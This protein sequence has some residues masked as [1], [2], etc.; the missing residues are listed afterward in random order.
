M[1]VAK[2]DSATGRFTTGYTAKIIKSAEINMDTLKAIAVVPNSDYIK[3]MAQNIGYFDTVI[4]IE[5]LEKQIISANLTNE[6]QSVNSLIGMN[7]AARKYKPFVYLTFSKEV[8]GSRQYLQLKMLSAKT[9]QDLLISEVHVD[10]MWKGFSDQTVLYPLFNTLI[11][12]LEAHSQ[13]YRNTA[14]SD[15]ANK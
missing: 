3:N 14:N 2:T 6:I 10:Y 4:T 1:K 11:D 15:T 5:E 7:N 13:I 8:K 12:Y 9:M